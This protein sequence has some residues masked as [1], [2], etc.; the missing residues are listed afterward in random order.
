MESS[1]IILEGTSGHSQGREM[2]MVLDF[3][4][5]NCTSEL[6]LF[7]YLSLYCR[8]PYLCNCLLISGRPWGPRQLPLEHSLSF[9]GQKLK[10]GYIHHFM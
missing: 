4:V 1:V 2:W 5:F 9:L 6:S 10:G 3:I 7:S 8:K